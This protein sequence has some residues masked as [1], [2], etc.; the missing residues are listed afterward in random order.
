MLINQNEA[1]KPKN[2]IWCTAGHMLLIVK[3]F[4]IF[5]VE[6]DKHIQIK[7]VEFL[8][9]TKYLNKN[10]SWEAEIPAHNPV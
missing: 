4:I 7:Y 10:A 9:R 3:R 8:W 6:C 2:T 1:L 5:C